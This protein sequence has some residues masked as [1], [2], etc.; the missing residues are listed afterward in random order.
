MFSSIS[1][2]LS[3][4][5]SYLNWSGA[6]LWVAFVLS[7]PVAIC[8][9]VLPWDELKKT[10]TGSALLDKALGWGLVAVVVVGVPLSGALLFAA[11]NA[12]DVLPKAVW[13][14]EDSFLG[15]VW[16][17]VRAIAGHWMRLVY[18][19]VPIGLIALGVSMFLAIPRIH[20]RVNAELEEAK[21][22]NAV[23]EEERD[24]ASNDSPT[25]PSNIA[26][27]NHPQPREGLVPDV[28]EGEK[29]PEGWTYRPET[30]GGH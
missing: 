7:F 6:G 21:R 25:V 28:S 5:G 24:L 10:P 16:L 3:L 23:D 12:I 18:C 1:N 15:Q 22:K 14:N 17:L 19:S 2:V 9:F 4:A 30:P 20:A 29:Y 26:I 13:R 27:T 11:W 8:V